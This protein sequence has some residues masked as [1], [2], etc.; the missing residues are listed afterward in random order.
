MDI[1]EILEH[2]RIIK[3]LEII[4]KKLNEKIDKNKI[5]LEVHEY[6][7]HGKISDKDRSEAHDFNGG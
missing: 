5:A 6:Q 2:N 1:K 4:I 3:E 7:Y